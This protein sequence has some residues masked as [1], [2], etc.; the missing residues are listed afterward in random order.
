MNIDNWLFDDLKQ[1]V[2]DFCKDQDMKN[3][4]WEDVKKGSEIGCKR[5]ENYKTRLNFKKIGIKII[6]YQIMKGGFFSSDFVQFMV[7][8]DIP[9]EERSRVPR[10]D[11]DFYQLRKCIKQQFP[12][13]LIPP[14]PKPNKSLADKVLVKRKTRF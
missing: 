8:T 1:A 10:K 6:H 13:M 2:A 4:V 14:L 12:N 5:I 11:A 9:G 3:G 7:E